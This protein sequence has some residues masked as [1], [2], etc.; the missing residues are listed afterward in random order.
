MDAYNTWKA[1]FGA[2]AAGG[3]QLGDYPFAPTGNPGNTA[4]LISEF[5]LDG[6]SQGQLIDQNYALSADGGCTDDTGA[7]CFA[8]EFEFALN[9]DPNEENNE[10]SH[11]NFNNFVDLQLGFDNSNIE[12]VEGSGGPDYGF[13]NS[14]GDTDDPENV[15]TGVEFSIPLAEIGATLG[16]GDIRIAAFVNSDNFEFV[17]NQFAGEG[18]QTDVE[19]E[20]GVLEGDAS[21]LGTLLFDTDGAGPIFTLAGIGGDQFVTVANSSALQVATGAVP[22]PSTLLLVVAA[23]ASL[24]CMR[25]RR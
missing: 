16:G 18:L 6:L 1:N 12:G 17:S 15:L 20:E 5:T 11:R 7:G 22:E 25:K 4:T 13:D 19:S 14:M 21:N 8:R 3:G 9:V 10:S 2:G 24:A 23:G